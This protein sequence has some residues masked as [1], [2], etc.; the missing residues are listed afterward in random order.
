VT[1]RSES[2]IVPWFDYGK[3]RLICSIRR[4]IP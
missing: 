1:K 3:C 4:A 2:L